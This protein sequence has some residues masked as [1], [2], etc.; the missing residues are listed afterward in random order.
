MRPTVICLTPVKNEAWILDRFLQATSLWADYIIIAD[1]MSTDGSREI[2]LNY[3]KV[4]LIDNKS[5]TYNEPERQ[6]LLIQEARKIS[7]K[8]LLITLD[9]DEL[10]TPNILNS[11]EWNM[12][13]ASEPGTVFKFQWANIRQ[14]FRTFW[15]AN[16]FPWGYMDDGYEHDSDSKIHNARIP[17][18]DYAEQITISD[19]KVM[20]FQFTD[21]KRMQ[22]KHRWYQC[23]EHVNFP[24]KSLLDIFRM[25][26]HMYAIDNESLNEMPENWIDDYK[27]LGINIKKQDKNGIYW[28]DEKILDYFDEYGVDYFRKIYLWDVN[29]NKIAKVWKRNQR[30]YKDPRNC[31]DKFIH[32]FLYYTQNIKDKYI[33]RKIENQIKKLFKY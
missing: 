23:Y 33:V 31:M 27:N 15:Y 25:Y 12:I 6:K 16:Y 24:E 32:L 9:A 2:A 18:P 30:K 26:H 29:W 20:H 1:Q 22:S 19:I 21:W 3:P 11:E 14:N 13:L 8:R 7:G 28:W 17:L 5:D 4:V 10:F